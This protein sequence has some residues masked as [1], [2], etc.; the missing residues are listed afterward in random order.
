MKN[1]K[2]NTALFGSIKAKDANGLHLQD[3]GGNGMFIKDGGNVGI[4]TTNPSAKLDIF[5]SSSSLK[6]TR[7]AGDRSAEMLYDGSKFLIK[8]PSGDRLSIT[9]SSSNELLTVNPNNGNVGIGTTNPA[10]K[11]HIHE[12][13]ESTAAQVHLTN[14]VTGATSDDGATLMMEDS[15]LFFRNRETNGTVQF[16]MQDGSIKAMTIDSSGNVGIGTTNPD[17]PLH[18]YSST[19]SSVGMRLTN[20]ADT[21]YYTDFSNGFIKGN[22]SNTNFKISLNDD[23]K[24]R[25]TSDGFVG[26]G[27]SNPAFGLH[28]ADQRNGSF[29]AEIKNTSSGTTGATGPHGLHIK[30]S[31]ASPDQ[32]HMDF[33]RCSDTTATRMRV[34]SD[35]DV[36]TSDSGFL[37]SDERLKT[38]IVDANPKLEDIKK[39][40]VRNFEWVPEFHPAKE[41]EKKIGFIAQELEEV[42][43][44]LVDEHDM[45]LGEEEIKRKS[46]R[47]GALIPI[48]V[49]GMQEQQQ[50]IDDLKSQNESLVARIEALEG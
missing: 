49:K 50:L 34:Y 39:L 23:E 36:W 5:G 24:M 48:L 7:D 46:V 27:T 8:T 41:G 14:A 3:D 44:G 32:T 42:F 11:L 19:S 40:K 31:A 25:I 15:N 4:G 18:I 30:Y 28:V 29:A 22:G 13:T 12:A 26:I 20:R 43:P 1:L 2:T 38:N 37:S 45:G 6:F 9:D 17:Q 16:Q 10:K 47:M 33:L 21:S 35:G